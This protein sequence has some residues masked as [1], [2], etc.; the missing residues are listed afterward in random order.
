MFTLANTSTLVE[1][2][3]INGYGG[4]QVGALLISPFVKPGST[5]SIAYNHYALLKSLEDIFKVDGHL[6]YAADNPA[7]G[8][9]LDTIGD[10]QNIFSSQ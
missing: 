4:D 5:S 8:Y 3:I 6:G 7:T 9:Q 2:I 10:D 1:N